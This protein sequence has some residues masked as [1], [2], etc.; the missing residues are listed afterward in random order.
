MDTTKRFCQPILPAGE[1]KILCD[2][3]PIL[4]DYFF[5]HYTQINPCYSETA[6]C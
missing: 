2:G 5:S 6:A 1:R 4:V 3:V